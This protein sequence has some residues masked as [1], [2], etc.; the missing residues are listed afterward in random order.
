[1]S[2]P[3]PARRWEL[4]GPRAALR[5]ARMAVATPPGLPMQPVQATSVLRWLGV[6]PQGAGAVAPVHQGAQSEPLARWEARTA[7]GGRRPAAPSRHSKFRGVRTPAPL[8]AEVHLRPLEPRAHPVVSFPVAGS[9]ATRDSG[10]HRRIQASEW[11]PPRSPS[12]AQERETAEAL[13]AR[14]AKARAVSLEGLR[15]AMSRILHSDAT[16][17]LARP[18]R[19]AAPVAA[20]W[21]GGQTAALNGTA[22]PPQVC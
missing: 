12:V 3:L 14:Q 19:A 11:C 13:Q 21:V 5:A 1:V 9:K 16:T 17:L 7:V 15:P 4:H 6:L 10:G 20:E 22:A 8:A 2:R 18:R